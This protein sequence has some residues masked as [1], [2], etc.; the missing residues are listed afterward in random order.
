[1]VV[2]FPPQP[3]DEIA[4]WHTLFDLKREVPENWTLIGGRLV[5]LHLVERGGTVVR[6]TVDADAVVD[7]RADTS[8]LLSFTAALNRLGFAPLTSGD[9][10]QHR[11]LLSLDK[12]PGRTVQV[13]VLIPEGVG[14]R[15]A[16]L[17]GIGGAPTIS[18]RGTTQALDRSMDVEVR[19]GDRTGT[20]PRPSLVST[21]VLKAAAA[22]E[23]TSG[24]GQRHV[25]D[26]LAL[27][28]VVAAEDF[29]SVALQ[30]KDKSRLRSI[31][32]KC[33]LEA[34]ALSDE[35]DR[36]LERVDRAIAGAPMHR[37]VRREDLDD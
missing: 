19:V 8:V 27:A 6:P 1:M 25:L 35:H 26:F 15:A 5:H 23:T 11:W 36:A 33:R 16:A 12:T 17:H 28:S 32:A 21:M 29:R 4:V 37:V 31:T 30:R 10:A 3:A 18:A 22:T 14:E 7:I 34:F 13:D 9:G 20:I 24:N 2:E